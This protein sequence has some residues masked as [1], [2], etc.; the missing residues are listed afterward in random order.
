M[1]LALALGRR[2]MG[3]TWPNPAVGCVIVKNGRVLGRGYTQSGGRPH[4]E[5]VALA[6]AGEGARRAVAYVT[7][8]PCAHH[9]KTPPC[10]EA[11]IKA[12]ICRVVSA[13]ED[14]DP[15]VA[16]KGHALLRAANIE[17]DVGC[18]QA[19]AAKDHAGF[20]QRATQAR[21]FVT[22]KLASSLDGRIA[23]SSGESQWITGPEARRLGQYL[24]ATHDAVM[25]GAGTARA[26]DPLLTVRDLGTKHQPVRIV[27]D[28]SLSVRRDSRLAQ[29]VGTAPLW[30]CHGQGLPSAKTDIWRDSEVKLIAC[31][32]ASGGLDLE[33]VL[34]RLASQG[35]TRIYCEGG[36]HLAASLLA[37]DAVDQLVMFS[38]GLALGASG[39]PSVA[40]LPEQAL[41]AF[42][43][44]RL[45][46]CR[47]IGGD[48]V[49][50]WRKP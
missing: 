34:R 31:A 14:P 21:P 18:L 6:Q 16:G 22:L 38:A 12:G 48:V 45:Q 9:G 26:D 50:F 43:R 23:T 44:F 36:G 15:R 47:E 33:D 13:M 25:V 39:V 2:N 49:S 41:D 8:E 4:A 30:L 29:S 20:L 24:R 1:K 19:L 40:E 17:V 35:L 27:C 7:L 11:L 37:L 3:R 5:T 42:C 10:A 28:T 32:R 46:D